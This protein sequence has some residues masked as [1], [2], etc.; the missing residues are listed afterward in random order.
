VTQVDTRQLIDALTQHSA[1]PANVRDEYERK[2]RRAAR[3]RLAV[4]GAISVVVLAG[5]A[6]T[7][8]RPW[9]SD[10]APRPTAAAR[11]TASAPRSTAASR[12]TAAAQ[13]SACENLPLRQRLT[14]ALRQGQSIVVGYGTL[15]GRNVPTNGGDYTG[16]R[17]RDVNTI[18]GPPLKQNAAW[19]IDIAGQDGSSAASD[20]TGPLWATDGRLFATA[21]PGTIA[22]NSIVGPILQVAPIV[23]GQVIFSAADC[24]NT[25]GLNARPYHGPLAQIP[26][27]QTNRQTEA[28]GFWA[29]PLSTVE[30]I[31]AS[32]EKAAAAQG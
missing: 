3:S 8:A 30:A 19:L 13:A 21:W 29:V 6:V 27:S 32:A 18:A 14:I 12:S 9:A 17:L 16:M 15:T 22:A 23:N 2:R 31:T 1:D 26:G 4:I 20:D 24:W 5:A 28:T 7:A 11:P 25:A 10:S